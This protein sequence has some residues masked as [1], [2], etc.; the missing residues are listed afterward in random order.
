MPLVNYNTLQKQKIWDGIIGAIH[1]SDK[2][3]MAHIEIDE[4]VV[5]PEHHHVHE[6]W[7]HVL[8]GIFEF[9]IDGEVQKLSH[10]MSMHIP[11]NVP[12]SGRAITKCKI[13]DC[14]IPVREE[15]KELEYI[16]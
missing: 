12:H 16:T 5:L 11:S 13:I 14:F 15:W 3:T 8:E 6:Q 9:T 1:H 7:S 2:S 10:G 4:G